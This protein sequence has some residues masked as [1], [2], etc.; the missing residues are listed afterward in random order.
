M[1]NKKVIIIIAVVFVVLLGGA[2]I[3]YNNLKDKVNNEQL[4]KT[5]EKDEEKETTKESAEEETADDEEDT[6]FAPDFTVY[7]SEGKEI[8]LSDYQG[9]PVILNF[10]ASWC[11]P[12]KS[13]LPDFEE[14]FKE[15]GDQIQFMMI[16]LTDGSRET[17]ESASALMEEQGYTFP[18]FYDT[19][20]Q[21]TG[22]YVNSGIPITYFIDE[23]GKFV[24]YGQGALDA[25]TLQSGIDMLLK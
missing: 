21:A 25:E 17:M 6:S 18:V 1:K 22:Q 8:R 14:A 7:D 5:E 24:A 12:C 11:G 20:Y 19:T 23:E 16:N 9:K 2:A 10:W 13:E 3:L 4:A 15:Y